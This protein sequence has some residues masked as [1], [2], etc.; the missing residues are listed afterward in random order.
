MSEHIIT[1]REEVQK[2]QRSFVGGIPRLPSNIAIP[3]CSLCGEEQTFFFQIELPKEIN[4]G[5]D[6]LAVLHA[7]H[8][9]VKTH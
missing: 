8:V 2:E 4:G 3:K 6:T 9:L 5:S 7:H 1:I